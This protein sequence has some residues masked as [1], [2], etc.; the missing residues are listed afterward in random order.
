MIA[1][2]GAGKLDE[3]VSAMLEIPLKPLSLHERVTTLT[4]EEMASLPLSKIVIRGR[5]SQQDGL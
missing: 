1:K 4:P 3:P 5:F 2:T